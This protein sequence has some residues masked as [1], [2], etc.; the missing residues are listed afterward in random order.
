MIS[1]DPGSN[2]WA[3]NLANTVSH[4]CKNKQV[5]SQEDFD[6]DL[7]I[8]TALEKPEL[9]AVLDLD[10]NWQKTSVD[11]DD[12]FYY[13]GTLERQGGGPL[14][15]VAASAI[16]MGMPAAIGLGM[17]IC[18]HFKPKYL[19]M[20]GICAG[21]K[22]NF[23]DVIVADKSWD[24]G[25]G[26]SKGVVSDSDDE[27]T[28]VESFGPA[29]T[30]IP[31]DAELVEKVKTFEREFDFAKHVRAR[32]DGQLLGHDISVRIGPMASGAAVLENRPKIELIK[33]FD[34]K[35]VGVEMEAYGIFLTSR[36]CPA[37]R[38]KALIVKSVCD[39]GDED[40]D[41]DWQALAAFTSAEFFWEFAKRY[42]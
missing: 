36:V 25:S 35:V 26:K 38:P 1:Y 32:W 37:P 19:A 27:K 9:S 30:S 4:I 2:A 23:G 7:A 15:I 28:V 13:Q 21:V 11:D 40:K 3:V 18:S 22:G 41:D 17:K 31:L 39:F 5:V 33:A 16:Q 29:P 34:R 24:Y 12:T 20:T 8:V 14:K 42:L 10:G 6:A